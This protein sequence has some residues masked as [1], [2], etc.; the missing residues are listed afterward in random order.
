M[1][2][3]YRSNRAE[4]LA[5]VLSEQLRLTPPELFETVEV[6]VN[7]WP[8]S[9]WLGEQLAVV[10]RI[11]ALVKFPFP[12]TYL[13]KI[14]KLL[15]GLESNIEDPWESSRLVWEV[16]DLLPE[17]LEKD[18]AAPL[19]EWINKRSSNSGHLKK[20]RWQLS[21]TIA[22]AFDDY[23]L[24]RPELI[25]DW[26][27]F[28]KDTEITISKLPANI[29]WQAL[30][31]RSLAQRINTKPFGL[32]VKEAI[33]K[34]REGEASL[35]K[36]PKQIHLFGLSSLA[37]IQLELI[38]AL[39]GAIDINVFLLTPCPDLWQRCRSR[40]EE[41]GNSWTTPPDGQ[42]LLKSPRL[43]AT[44][45][46]MG[47]EFQQ[48]LEGSGESQL[49]I[50]K[51]GDLFAA[52]ANI[53]TQ[54]GRNPT[55]LEQL[56][57][58]LINQEDQKSL[59]RE[60]IDNSLLFLACPGKWRE[61]QLVRDQILQ[62]L[63]KDPSLEPRDI[64]IMTPQIKQFAPII[65]SVF[66]DVAAT[67]V[68]LPW[69]ITDRSQQDNPGLT[70]YM[71]DFLQLAGKRFTSSE[72][73]SLLS[74][75]A[76]QKQQGLTQDDTS[77]ISNYLQ[78]TGFRWGIDG[79]ER[80]GEQTHSLSW[81]LDRWL[82]GL[83]LPSTPGIA[84]KGVAPFSTKLRP[85]ELTNWWGLLSKISNHLQKIRYPHTCK[86]WVKILK[87]FIYDF[88]GDGGP[89][90]WE[91]QCFLNA[92]EDWK[93][94]AGEYELKLDAVVVADVLS[95]ALSHESGRFG[96]RS[97]KLTISALEPMRAI[98]Y[99]VIVL[100][101]IDSKIFPRN[102][103]RPNFH[104]LENKR[105]LG[106]PRNSDRDRYVLLEALMSSRQHLMITWNSRNE[107]TGEITPAA[108][109]VQQW[110]GYLKNQLDPDQFMGLL[111][112]PP[113]NPLDRNNFIVDGERCA[114]SCDKRNLE[115]RLW[116]D[117][118]LGVEPIALAL[119]LTWDI[120]PTNSDS[121]L[122]FDAL[123]SWLKAPQL[124]W[125]QHHQIKPRESISLIEDLDRVDLNELQRHFLLKER[126][127]ELLDLFNKD[128]SLTLNN[129]T[130]GD[131]EYRHA[132]QGIL[133]P[134]AAAHIESERLESRWQSLQSTL[135]NLGTC[136]TRL[137]E[138]SDQSMNLLWAGDFL[139]IVQL[140]SLKHKAVMEGWLL[141]LANC[142]IANA[143]KATVVVARSTNKTKSDT[144]EVA[145]KWKPL[146]INEAEYHL[147]ELRSIAN[148]GIKNCW[149][150]PPESGWEYSKA[151]R[152][153]PLVAG[154][155]FKRKWCGD[156]NSPGE[157]KKT[158]MQM[159]FGLDCEA[160]TFL[161]SNEFSWACSMLY[162]PLIENL[163]E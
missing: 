48:L 14:T 52:P 5:S 102:K 118:K 82:L 140:G 114:N 112:E 53:A 98:P 135:L 87:G 139:V 159:C 81:C 6:V 11:N 103:E 155:S 151:N 36:L 121:D 27:G 9:R 80:G 42:W 70:Q 13:R 3:V 147:R 109:P 113:P 47:A 123:I 108:T 145:L 156:F 131:W 17:L 162:E 154:S 99:R 18:E 138:M 93:L 106:D 37:P 143:P 157:R 91:R 57:Q 122:P 152:K 19:R 62:W 74:N 40:R 50:W 158:E 92:L 8:T 142:A 21:Q 104:L 132:G 30:F 150:V 34:L 137:L 94:V 25:N 7:T 20:E 28:N 101:G 83:V 141:H 41:L 95:K 115:A 59:T 116:L 23:V 33:A 128:K 1:L 119:P 161:E 67:N 124:M 96:H 129:S 68:D 136:K 117:K 133:P 56:Q 54:S 72:L 90:I 107:R 32:Q 86:E 120:P 149:P 38:Q 84:P 105:Q 134:K 60:K 43:E 126:F 64:L 63:A 78:L 69:R 51:D 15:L 111:Q 2:T 66:N 153:N 4:W 24:Y 144:F 71:L 148:Q 49:G 160:S 97:G 125:L 58:Q 127:D 85:T 35:K 46:R 89:W 31:L 88:F 110:L 65:A 39:S 77:N 26:L 76:I 61:V 73:D 146:S 163:E 75:P 44:L 22:D 45:G 55:F 79:E 10:N 29:R 16:I 12:G 100:M 130:K